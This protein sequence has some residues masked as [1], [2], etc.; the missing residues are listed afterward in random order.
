MSKINPLK[1]G[2]WGAV[3][4]PRVHWEDSDGGFELG[5]S[6]DN[7]CP[8]TSCFRRMQSLDGSFLQRR[9]EAAD[10]K[11]LGGGAI[12]DNTFSGFADTTVSADSQTQHRGCFREK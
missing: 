9:H 11:V 7:V 8:G 5:Q 3:R 12:M 6:Q 1:C 4:H 10:R 2:G